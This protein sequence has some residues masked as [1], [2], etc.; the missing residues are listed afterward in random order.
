M[1]TQ[2]EARRLARCRTLLAVAEGKV[3]RVRDDHPQRRDLQRKLN[4]TRDK[5]AAAERASR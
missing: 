5:L 2:A 3:G 4:A 1:T